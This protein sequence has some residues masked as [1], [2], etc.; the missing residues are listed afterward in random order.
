MSGHA[1]LQAHVNTLLRST[2]SI[3]KHVA[4]KKLPLSVFGAPAGAD[5]E[6]DC[7]GVRDPDSNEEWICQSH[8]HDPLQARNAAQTRRLTSMLRRTVSA[9]TPRNR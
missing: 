2:R 4:G 6:Y 9:L 7:R 1:C 5:C 3:C 8:R